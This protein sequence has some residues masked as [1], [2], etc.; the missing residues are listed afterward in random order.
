[1]RR[2]AVGCGHHV[3]HDA[4][5]GQERI[6]AQRHGR[7]AGVGFHAGHGAVKPANA[8][9]ALH[10]ANGDV[11]VFEHRALFNV[12]FKVGANW[13]LA[14]LFGA[15]VANARQLVFDRFAFGVGGG[16]GMLQR[17]GFGKHARAHHHRHKARAFFVG[18][19]HNF[20]WGRGSDPRVVQCLENL[21]AS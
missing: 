7:G 2:V 15:D 18:P 4:G 11:V 10:H 8:Q 1:M 19:D 6:L 3:L 20:K 9:H 14:R 12:G 17:E 16:I 13:V 5:G 21:K